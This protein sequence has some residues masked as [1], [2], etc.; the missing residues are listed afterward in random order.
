MYLV[1]YSKRSVFFAKWGIGTDTESG[2]CAFPV[3]GPRFESGGLTPKPLQKGF[4]VSVI[5]E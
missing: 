3:S 5:P 2:F 4:L 1:F